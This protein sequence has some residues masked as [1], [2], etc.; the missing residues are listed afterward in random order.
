MK[1][2]T[3]A[4]RLGIYLPAAPE[5]FQRTALTHAE[6]AELQHNPPQWLTDL[7]ATGPH[8]RPEVA[9]KLGVTVAALKRNDMDR[10]LTTAEIKALLADQPEWLRKARTTL[11]EE[12]EA[13][14]AREAAARTDDETDTGNT[15]HAG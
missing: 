13:A 7:R 10:P 1:P 3:A 11:A 6:F 4:K 12:R 15:P 8:P 9:R 14:A 5:E 2:L